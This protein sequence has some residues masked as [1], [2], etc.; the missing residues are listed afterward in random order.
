MKTSTKNNGNDFIIESVQNKNSESIGYIATYLFPFLFQSYSSFDEIICFL[1]LIFVIYIIY[2]H[3]TMIV[4]NPVLN[5]IYSLYDI[6]YIDA[7]SKKRM[8]GTFIIDCPFVEKGDTIRSKKLGANLYFG[9]LK[10]QED[11]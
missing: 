7:K 9:I 8:Q 4:V 6:I 3:S 10:E 5:T 1:V 11:E 2:T